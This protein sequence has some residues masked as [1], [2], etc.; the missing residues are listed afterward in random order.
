MHI[1]Q[2][3]NTKLYKAQSFWLSSFYVIIIQKI[4]RFLISSVLYYFCASFHQIINNM[5][6][7]VI[8]QCYQRTKEWNRTKWS[9][10]WIT[11]NKRV[12]FGVPKINE[13]II[14]KIYQM[15]VITWNFEN[16]FIH[17]IDAL[18][19]RRNF[20]ARCLLWDGTIVRTATTKYVL[21]IFYR[22]F[23]H[24]G[25]SELKISN[26]KPNTCPEADGIWFCCVITNVYDARCWML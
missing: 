3:Q 16:V 21:C 26:L 14:D 6:S 20:I 19:V 4:L 15:Y 8:W 13:K 17:L 12:Q 5:C 9:A 18:H 11:K 24:L 25:N 23:Q 2:I 1:H 7:T 10:K 22:T